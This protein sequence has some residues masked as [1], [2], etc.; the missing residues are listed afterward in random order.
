MENKEKNT[1]AK[2]EAKVK[3]N[4]KR[5]KKEKVKK[6]PVDETLDWLRSLVLTFI[7]VVLLF[8]FAVKTARVN[9]TSMNHTLEDRDF[10][11]LRSLFYTPEQGDIIAANCWGLDEIIV[12]R[13]I[14]VGG[15]TV[16]IDFMTG[17]VYVDGV[18]LD[19]PYINNLTTNDEGAFDYPLTVDEGY[20]FCLGDNRQVSKD[21]RHPDVGLINREDILGKAFLRVYPL[22]K[23]TF[24]R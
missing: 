3:V 13:I 16:D 5:K 6:N 4:G 12:K 7:T 23:I 22:D 14:A 2:S 17:T 21:S 20:Y 9:G 19:E 1:A 10:L 24:F 15:Q 18:A 11:V 8:T